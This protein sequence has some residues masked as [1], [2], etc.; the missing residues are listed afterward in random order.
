MIKRT[1]LAVA[2]LAS[3]FT[4]TTFAHT[5][6]FA[7]QQDKLAILYGH[8]DSNDAYKPEKVKSLMGY[9]K[10]QK[11]EVKRKDY[12]DFVAVE[13]E[14]MDVIGAEFY[15]GI[16]TKLKNG[17]YIPQPRSEVSGE[18][19]TANESVKYPVTILNPEVK[20]QPLGYQLEIVPEKN[21]IPLHVG[22]KLTVQVLFEGKPIEGVKITNDYLNLGKDNYQETDK[23]GKASLVIRNEALNVFEAK[24]KIDYP[25]KTKADKRS[26][27]ATY[28]FVLKRHH[29]H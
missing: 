13:P 16:W 10:G 26:L 12:E 24:Y 29:H 7:I 2:L 27:S 6:W 19:E 22:D 20:P 14:N 4:A 17:K 3:L 9:A 21:P 23:E 1:S 5:A 18:I 25:D 11:V 8:G 28:S 15:S